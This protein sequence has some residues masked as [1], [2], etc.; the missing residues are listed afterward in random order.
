MPNEKYSIRALKRSIAE[1]TDWASLLI[2]IEN[3]QQYVEVYTEFAG[4]KVVQTL[5][6]IIKSTLT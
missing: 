2:S 4:D 5:I 6:A 1:N 3:F